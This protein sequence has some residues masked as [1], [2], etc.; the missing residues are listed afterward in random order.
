MLAGS[1]LK[2][3]AVGDENFLLGH[4]VA[5]DGVRLNGVENIRTIGDVAEDDVSAVEMRGLIEAEEELG[6]VGSWASVGHGEDTSASVLVDEVLI[7][8]VGSVDGLTTGAISLSEVTALS[9]EASDDSVELGAL[10][11][12][13][14]S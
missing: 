12:E 13:G 3:T 11:M 6:A 9:H 5:A 4:V 7:G 14:L 2:L 8:E 1:S 10:E